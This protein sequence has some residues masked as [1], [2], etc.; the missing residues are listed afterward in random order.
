MLLELLRAG[1]GGRASRYLFRSGLRHWCASP[2][3]RSFVDAE[4]GAGF[5]A[6]GYVDPSL[7]SKQRTRV[8]LPLTQSRTGRNSASR[9]HVVT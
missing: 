8:R 9:P 1:S 2:F 5:G 3:S 6:D 4:C 7:A